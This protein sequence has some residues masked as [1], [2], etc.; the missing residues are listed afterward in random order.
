MHRLVLF[1]SVAALFTAS[2]ASAQQTYRTSTGPYG[3]DFSGVEIGPDLAYGFG[4]SAPYY[5]SGGAFGGHVGYN[6]QSQQLL[7]GVEADALGTNLSTGQGGPFSFS[8]KFLTSLRGKA[9]YVFGDL[10]AYGT[11]GVGWGTTE[12][13]NW[14]GSRGATVNGAVFGVGA[15][16]ALTRNVSF[17]AEVIR[18]QFGDLTYSGAYPFLSQTVS[19]ST[20][21]MRVGASLHF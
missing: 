9:G 14:L 4:T 15:E 3:A 12:Y 16:Y 8:E 1:A 11:L 7:G 2:A 10:M 6:L 18:Y 5:T 17:R 19:A 21:L 20:N 13:T